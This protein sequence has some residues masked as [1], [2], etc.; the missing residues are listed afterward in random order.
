MEKVHRRDYYLFSNIFENFFGEVTNF[1][2]FFRLKIFVPF[3]VFALCILVPVNWGGRSLEDLKDV[4]FS[5]IDKLSIS[6]VAP[7][8]ERFV[9]L[10]SIH[11]YF[12]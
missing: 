5:D 3:M 12:A 4:T 7:R 10:Y 9:I 6:N 2:M 1:L 11:Y 8:S